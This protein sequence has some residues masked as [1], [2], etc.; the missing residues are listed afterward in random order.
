[1]QTSMGIT[2]RDYERLPS[3]VKSKAATL[4][5]NLKAGL[6]RHGFSLNFLGHDGLWKNLTPWKFLA[7][8]ED[9]YQRLVKGS[10]LVRPRPRE[11]LLE[12]IS[13][14]YNLVKQSPKLDDRGLDFWSKV[15]L[16]R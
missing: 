13:E 6:Q 4:F 14:L 10:K 8:P 2:R 5:A 9:H 7:L 12:Q 11:D 3:D 1:M 16:S 15:T